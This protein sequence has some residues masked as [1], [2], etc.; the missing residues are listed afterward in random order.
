MQDVFTFLSIKLDPLW[1]WNAN[2]DILIFDLGIVCSDNSV[3]LRYVLE[4]GTSENVTYFYFSLKEG[5]DR[6]NL[7]II[8]EYIVRVRLVM[9]GL[10]RSVKF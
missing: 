6:E 9:K 2:F 3:L 10:S 7:G 5:V 1:M 4:L 8:V